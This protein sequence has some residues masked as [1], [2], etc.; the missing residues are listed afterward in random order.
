M[1]GRLRE[2]VGATYGE[3]TNLTVPV[4][5]RAA[6]GAPLAVPDDAAATAWADA[7]VAE[8][9]EP[10]AHYEHPHLGRWPAVTSHEH[11]A[12]RVTYVGT[13]PNR[14]LAVALARWLRSPDA[15]NA[16]WGALPDA[17]TVTGARNPRGE[18]V[19]FVS[20]WSWEPATL[21]L[22]A[23][24]RDLLSGEELA[25]GA[26]LALEAW[27]VRVLVEAGLDDDA[28]GAVRHR[29]ADVIAARPDWSV[30][31][32][33]RNGPM[34]RARVRA[35]LSSRRRELPRAGR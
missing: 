3:Y 19:R 6:A 26:A 2:A 16:D 28:R 23:P 35:C 22:P 25:E 10:L 20:N 5:V 31:G 13:L 21:A 32:R 14:A 4:P 15:A 11:G 9:A 29:G 30:A 24:A 1:P 33:D 17:V 7:L 18:R 12:G 8:G 34:T 27:D